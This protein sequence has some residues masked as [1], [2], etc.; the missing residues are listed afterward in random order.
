MN[1]RD[2]KVLMFDCFGTLIDWE[3]GML[4]A[5]APLTDKLDGN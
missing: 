5:L 2:F 4:K 1:L 3:S